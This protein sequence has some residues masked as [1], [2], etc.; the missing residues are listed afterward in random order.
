MYAGL[1]GAWLGLG[2]LKFGN[3]VVL[4]KMVEK[5]VDAWEWI[6]QP[7]P[8]A[9]GYLG[10]VALAILG[11]VAFRPK[12]DAKHWLLALPAVWL[13]WQWIAS[14]GSVDPALSRVTLPH[15]TVAAGFFYLGLTMLG[16]ARSMP[17]FWWALILA[18]AYV[19]WFGLDQHAGGLEAT[20]KAFYENT[21]NWQSYPPDFIKKIESNRIFSTLVYPNALAGSI[22]LL[23]APAAVCLWGQSERWPKILRGVAVGCL[24][25]LGL[26][27]LVWTESRSGWLIALV[28]IVVAFLRQPLPVKTKIMVAGAVCVTGLVAFAI[29]NQAYFKRGA[30]SVSARGDYWRAAVHTFREHPVFGAGPGTFATTYSKI[31]P[32]G[33]EMAK[34]AHNDYLEQASDSGAPGFILYLAFW[35]G[36]M[37][38][39][40]GRLRDDPRLFAVWLG[41]LGWSLQGLVEFGLYIPALAWLAF[42]LTGW[43]WG[44][45]ASRNGIDTQGS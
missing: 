32:A 42:L 33:A 19:L 27:C 21:P 43:L 31:K 17:L 5:P 14:A 9:W 34:L 24:I 13:G 29:R 11:L 6:L 23:L 39:L 36:S 41:L 25:Y 38:L 10:T 45:T 37:W 20:R 28:L 12:L 2:L 15:F 30:T 3:P 18:F 40:F 1:V 7:W 4:D 44:A 22:L 8:L 35:A 16:R 26:A